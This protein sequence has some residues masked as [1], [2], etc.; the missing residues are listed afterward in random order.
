MKLTKQNYYTP[1]NTYL[2]ASKL[3]DYLY[4]PFYFY[5][6]HI[7]HEIPHKDTPSM[8]IGRAVDTIL[9]GS[10]RQFTTK[11]EVVGRRSKG[12][13]SNLHQLNE[14]EYQ[15]VLKIV[16]AVVDTEAYQYIKK[17]KFISQRILQNNY[18]L[19]GIFFSGMCGIPDW[20]SIGKDRAVIVDL[21]T[22]QDID[23]RAFSYSIKK[24]EYVLQLAFYR[25]LLRETKKLPKDFP[26]D[27]YLLAVENDNEFPRVELF[28]LNSFELDGVEKVQIPELIGQI[29]EMKEWKPKKVSFENPIHL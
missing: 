22:T 17:N 18:S 15:K 20:Y 9:T 2:S 6:K 28:E 5:R 8:L 13:E 1:R 26:I 4:D 21:K 16:A 27:C 11:F 12:S 19:V 23:V 25:K 14:T 24:F 3:K 10:W 7:L 29:A